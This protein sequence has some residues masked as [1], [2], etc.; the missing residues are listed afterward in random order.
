[1]IGMPD[2]DADFD[3][4]D[5]YARWAHRSSA[6]ATLCMDTSASRPPKHTPSDDGGLWRSVERR[7]RLQ[8]CRA[9][10]WGSKEAT[11]FEALEGMLNE[12]VECGSAVAPADALAAALAV[13]LG[14][15][16]SGGLVAALPDPMHRLFLHSLAQYHGVPA[17]S[18][19]V[20]G[21]RRV[22]CGSRT[23]ARTVAGRS[24]T[25]AARGPVCFESCRRH[26]SRAGERAGGS[27]A[28]SRGLEAGPGIMPWLMHRK[29]GDRLW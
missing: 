25:R 16:G 1:M 6:A 11:L 23:A 5:L 15:D 10:M 28:P 12:F 2:A 18:T 17:R 14:L 27:H 9:L 22:S 3:R 29:H 4:S 7:H 8:L 24:S 19:T 20:D 26:E 21:G 13:P